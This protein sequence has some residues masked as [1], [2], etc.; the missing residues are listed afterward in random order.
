MSDLRMDQLTW[1][2]GTGAGNDMLEGA[3]K[4]AQS[5]S[6]TLLLLLLLLL[7]TSCKTEKG[8]AWPQPAN[9]CQTWRC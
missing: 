2:L 3:S 5:P 8:S 4:D 6:F 7:L 9:C 1:M